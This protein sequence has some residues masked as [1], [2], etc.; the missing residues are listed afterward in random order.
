MKR[1]DE[2]GG[3]CGL[4]AGACLGDEETIWAGPPHGK[5]ELVI[6]ERERF[7]RVGTFGRGVARDLFRLDSL[8]LLCEYRSSSLLFLALSFRPVLAA[9]VRSCPDSLCNFKKGN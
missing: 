3:R 2:H 4:D 7:S 1:N 6:K 5:V 8:A 9:L